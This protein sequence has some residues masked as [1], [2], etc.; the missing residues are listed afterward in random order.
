MA[1][2]HVN[3]PNG[4]VY[5]VTAPDTATQ[6]QVV[7]FAQQQHAQS[8][9]AAAPKPKKSSVW[10]QV[11]AFAQSATEQVPFLD[12]AAAGVTALT[13]G[14]SYDEVRQ[15][16]QRLAAEDRAQ[17]PLARNAGGVAGFGATLA[18]PGGA[19][20]RGGKGFAQA[21]GRSAQVGAAY[22][23]LQ[24]AAT[25]DGGLANRAVGA[26]KGAALGGAVGGAAPAVVRAAASIPGAARRVGSAAVATGQTIAQNLGREAPEAVVTPKATQNAVQYVA[27]LARKAKVTPEVLEAHPSIAAGEPITS[28]EALGRT[29]VSQA[30]ALS[31]RT[32][33]TGDLAEGQL[34]TRA[35]EAGQR[36]LG[37]LADT[38]KVSPEGAQG[39]ID[40]IV[41]AG[42]KRAAPLFD[43]A[44][45]SSA[46]VWNPE[47]AQLAQRPVV[48]KALAAVADDLRN[49]G[50]DP[51]AI[52][53][54]IQRTTSPREVQAGRMI[55][56]PPTTTESATAVARPTAQTWDMVKK[57]IAR[58][59]ERHPL[60]NKPLA[61]SQSA[62]NFG[63]NS[64]ERSLT[65]SLRKHIPGYAEALDASGDYLSVSGA[66]QRANGSL[67]S[68]KVTPAQFQKMW[69]SWKSPAEADAARNALASEIFN[70]AQNGLLRPGRLLVPAVR[71]KLATA[72]GPEAADELISRVKIQAKNTTTGNRIRP[73]TNSTTAET[74]LAGAEQD[75]ALADG[76]LKAG[77]HLVMGRPGKAAGAMVNALAA[78]VRG[79]LTPLN[80][81]T[82]DEVGRLLL[83]PPNELAAILRK[84]GYSPS[85][86]LTVSSRAA[87]AVSGAAAGS[88]TNP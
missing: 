54:I 51:S 59:V 81:A 1:V 72:F 3:G 33:T 68:T 28:A 17:R 7:A 67:F 39:G 23:A 71:Q 27:D 82:R 42:R 78:P 70:K 18:A 40:A 53:W 9:P 58:Q 14:K 86:K 66:F 34:A 74:M 13:T 77:G 48:R 25:A 60:T 30:V 11:G 61:D 10:D 63:V 8:A 73:Y 76:A 75:S 79:A 83:M 85:P 37:H 52:E 55:P 41:E 57:A 84:A 46:P 15:V 32:G 4:E 29:G 49:A 2:F 47:L 16:Q 19:Y 64:A 35:E 87:P 5:E 26:A 24:G 20:I 65:A 6:A 50:E 45:A 69:G 31:R 22:G 21:A 36:L 56:T 44:L 80:Q 62:G 43:T 88:V 12:E 38:G